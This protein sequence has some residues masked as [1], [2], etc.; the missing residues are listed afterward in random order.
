M[1]ANRVAAAALAAFAAALGGLVT[2]MPLWI[3]AGVLISAA[4]IVLRQPR[5]DEAEHAPP[6][7]LREGEAQ[8]RTPCERTI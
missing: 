8:T 6:N 3:P 5:E 7:G 1:G 4:A 2:A